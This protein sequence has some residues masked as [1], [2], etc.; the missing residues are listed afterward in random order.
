MLHCF[1]GRSGGGGGCGGSRGGGGASGTRRCRQLIACKCELYESRVASTNDGR[2]WLPSHV[3]QLIE[4]EVQSMERGRVVLECACDCVDRAELRVGEMQ[5][6]ERAV[7]LKERA[8]DAVAA[9]S[10]LVA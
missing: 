4:V 9:I 3:C 8:E 2:Q 1:V 7:G 5:R 10:Q 6:T